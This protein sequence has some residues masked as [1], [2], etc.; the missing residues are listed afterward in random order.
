MADRR[1]RRRKKPGT[2]DI[3]VGSFSDIAFLLIIFFILATTLSQLSGFMADIP[4]GEKSDK[5][6]QTTPTVQIF[7]SR[8]VWNRDD[9]NVLQLRQRLRDMDMAKRKD[10]DRV[11]ILEAGGNVDYQTYY[12][13]M[14]TI[15]ASGGIIAIA[16]EAESK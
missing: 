11:V 14:A 5:Q 4:A 2:P 16:R 1:K 8:I 9:V 12:D 6:Q 7:G 13:V 3:P 15:S 10:S